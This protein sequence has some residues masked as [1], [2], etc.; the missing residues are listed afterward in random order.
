MAFNLKKALAG[1]V[2]GGP[3]GAVIGGVQKGKGLRS[4]DG[5][6]PKAV[7]Q[8]LGGYYDDSWGQLLG[9]MQE[10]QG[11]D[12]LLQR[13]LAN[14]KGKPGNLED[15]L[16]QAG[17]FLGAAGVSKLGASPGL[18]YMADQKNWDLGAMGGYG[19]AAGQI[20]QGARRSI[21]AGNQQLAAAGLGRSSARGSQTGALQQQAYG[22]QA[23]LWADTYQRAQQNRMQSATNLFDAHRT[24][25]QLAMGQVPTP[26]MVDSGGGGGGL[27]GSLGALA[28]GVGAGAAIGGPIGGLVGGGL[29][30][31]ASALGKR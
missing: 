12:E 26:R 21:D 27:A 5:T 30:A 16:R 19:A 23:G 22:Q 20:G 14:F 24:L 8:G 25:A 6:V 4:T 3:T 15:F 2:V 31:G 1:L 11:T 13:V 9:G 18:A 7:P 10:G 17:P 29:F 28:T